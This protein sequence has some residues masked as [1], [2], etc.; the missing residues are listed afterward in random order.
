MADADNSGHYRPVD[1]LRVDAE[2]DG[3]RIDNFLAFRLR[4][5]PRMRLYRL[6]RRGEIR[7]NRGRVRQDYRLRVRDQIRLPPL[8]LLPANES[9]P[10]SDSLRRELESR[11]L[12]EDERLLVVDKPA[13]LAVHGGSGLRHSL[14]AA[15]RHLRPDAPFLGLAHR[16]DRD[17]SGCLLLCKD[18]RWLRE[19]QAKFRQGRV[20]KSY[21]ALI[22][23]CPSRPRLRV[24]LPLA[25]A[26]NADRRRVVVSPQGRA[27]AT[28]LQLRRSYGR[29]SLVSLRIPTGRTHQIRVH[30][31]SIGHPLGG[32]RKYG[33][34]DFNRWLRQQGLV[35][36]FLHADTLSW[37][38]PPAA[39][40][41]RAPLPEELRSVLRRLADCPDAPERV[42]HIG[43]G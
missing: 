16:L 28:N 7:V 40:P 36:L 14:L 33:A 29:A 35:R 25:R 10:P 21:L 18:Y 17:A 8:Y 24:E 42:R 34:P 15:L 1:Y 6:L 38:G 43:K 23:G 20:R 27:A 13:G 9:P 3:Q 5:L 22:R 41:L 11:I 19:L 2:H 4:S 37:S 39:P 12:H 31:A 32:D 30:T 26:G